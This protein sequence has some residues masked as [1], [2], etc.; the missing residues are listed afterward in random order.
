MHLSALS[1][2]AWLSQEQFGAKT[3]DTVVAECLRAELTALGEVRRWVLQQRV[4]KRLSL[5]LADSEQVERVFR[6]LASIGDLSVGPGGVVVPAPLRVVTTWSGALLVGSVPTQELRRWAPSLQADVI[7]RRVGDE[8][9]AKTAA[10][11]L[12]GAHITVER[13]SGL[14]R[15]PAWRD[16][17]ARLGDRAGDARQDERALSLSWAQPWAY[18]IGGTWER[19]SGSDNLRLQRARQPGSWWAYAWGADPATPQNLYVLTSDEAQRTQLA[20]DAL[21]DRPRTL[22]ATRQSGMVRLKLGFRLPY[23]EYRFLLAQ[24]ARLIE[25][26]VMNLSELIWDAAQTKLKERL[27]IAV[28]EVAL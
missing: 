6:E 10:E 4:T 14:E 15:T 27:G 21:Q 5:V 1:R 7:L 8:H 25:S 17:L 24:G 3:S 11:A 16:W 28:R 19:A 26:S 9:E 18:K 23:A 2:E 12:Q 22:D 20:L 13:W